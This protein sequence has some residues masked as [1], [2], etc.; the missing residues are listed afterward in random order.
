MGKGGGRDCGMGTRSPLGRIFFPRRYPLV[1]DYQGDGRG[2]L[3]F[4]TNERV[5]LDA[6]LRPKFNRAPAG[7]ALNSRSLRESCTMDG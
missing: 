6:S 3:D 1:P 7:A 2:A 5:S 4:D